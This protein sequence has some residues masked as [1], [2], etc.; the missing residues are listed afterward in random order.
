MADGAEIL[1]HW[2]ANAASVRS[3]AAWATLATVPER[4]PRRPRLLVWTCP[5]FLDAP[6]LSALVVSSHLLSYS[7]GE[8]KARE[9]NAGAGGFRRPR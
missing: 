2:R 1:V 3:R 5:A 6:T 7:S 4:I 9:V 8:A